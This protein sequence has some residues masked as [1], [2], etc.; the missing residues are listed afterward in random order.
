MKLNI[1]TLS[2]KIGLRCIVFLV[3]ALGRLWGGEVIWYPLYGASHDG[4]VPI[5]GIAQ[6]GSEVY[7]LQPILYF[8]DTC[9]LPSWRVPVEFPTLFLVSCDYYYPAEPDNRL[10]NSEFE[11]IGK[12]DYDLGTGWIHHRKG[13]DGCV[14]P[15]TGVSMGWLY[16]QD[17]PWVYFWN[18]GWRYVEE[19]GIAWNANAWW[20]Y[21]PGTG[22]LWTTRQIYP[23]I[24]RPESGWQLD[25]GAPQ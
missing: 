8:A 12:Y 21:E 25:D 18:R 5:T 6:I 7:L 14:E 17:Y 9:D 11:A 10:V 19:A 4:M 20:M 3:V 22:W 23:W 1:Q 24:F 16:V 15:K 2:L 13:L